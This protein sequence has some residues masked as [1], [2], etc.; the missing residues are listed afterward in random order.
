M[1]MLFGVLFVLYSNPLNFDLQLLHLPWHQEADYF[2]VP[3]HTWCDRMIFRMNQ[4]LE[5]KNQATDGWARILWA[6]N[7]LDT[8]KTWENKSWLTIGEILQPAGEWQVQKFGFIF[9]ALE[10]GSHCTKWTV[11]Q[12]FWYMF[13]MYPLLFNLL[14]WQVL[15]EHDIALRSREP[16]GD[17]SAVYLDLMKRKE[18]FVWFSENT[19]SR[20]DYD[21]YQQLVRRY[22]HIDI[23]C[24]N[25]KWISQGTHCLS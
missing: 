24:H 13:H 20:N 6:P 17:I 8:E 1:F 11:W 9:K 3:W 16:I 4:R 25:Y 14:N 18:R 15:C 22:H 2:L 7:T 23:W 12:T 19:V 21:C 10:S 5:S